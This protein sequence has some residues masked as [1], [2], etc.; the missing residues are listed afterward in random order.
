ADSWRHP[1]D[2]DTA[3]APTHLAP[4]YP[5]PREDWGPSVGV[6][7]C[8]KVPFTP[9]LNASLTNSTAD[10][11]TRLDLHIRFPERCWAPVGSAGYEAAEVCQSDLRD[12]EIA[13]PEGVS[14]NPAAASGLAACSPGQVG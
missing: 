14:L 12:A 11:P 7:G 2:F 5:Y 9:T 10:S 8:G 6:D 4:G 3:S 1:G 13:L